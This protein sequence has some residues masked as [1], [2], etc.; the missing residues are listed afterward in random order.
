MASR[1]AEKH[2]VLR[3]VEHIPIVYASICRL[4]ERGT[5]GTRKVH[6]E[7]QDPNGRQ[8]VMALDALTVWTYWTFAGLALN[9]CGKSHTGQDAT[10]A[11]RNGIQRS[12]PAHSG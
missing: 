7:C 11:Q 6:L 12:K 4:N 10:M 1:L 8:S 2:L 9:Q 3:R 5:Y